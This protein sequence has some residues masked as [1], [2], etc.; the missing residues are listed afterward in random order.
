[1]INA[2]PD[3]AARCAA[4]NGATT[5]KQTAHGP[6]SAKT[7]LSPSGPNG[8]PVDTGPGPAVM[9]KQRHPP[10]Q[11][12]RPRRRRVNSRASHRHQNSS[13][14]AA[15]LACRLAPDEAL[16]SDDFGSAEEAG[17]GARAATRTLSVSDPPLTKRRRKP[18]P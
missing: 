1:M 15:C 18:G 11:T 4:A 17:E 13:V 7:R 2:W 8:R 10:Q 14:V 16:D 3:H 5:A 9:P 12:Y 6:A